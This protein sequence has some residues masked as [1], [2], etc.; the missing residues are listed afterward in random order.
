MFTLVCVPYNY[1]PLFRVCGEPF[2]TSP[3]YTTVIGGS[4]G[5]ESLAATVATLKQ[6]GRDRQVQQHHLAW[7]GSINCRM[8][9][10]IITH[11]ECT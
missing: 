4:Q 6:K 2:S 10:T 8:A 7:S 1:K 5:P 11:S 9:L 3:L